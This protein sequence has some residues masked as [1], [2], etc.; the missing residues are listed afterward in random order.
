MSAD[1]FDLMDKAIMKQELFE[2]L[3]KMRTQVSPGPDGLTVSFYLLFW[4]QISDTLVASCLFS[5][6]QGTM[7]ASQ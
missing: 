4:Q 5:Q 7:S 2:A 1:S 3:G 6:Q